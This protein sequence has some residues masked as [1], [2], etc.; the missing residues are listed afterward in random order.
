MPRLLRYLAG[1][2]AAAVV[3]CLGALVVLVVGTT[4]VENAGGLAREAQGRALALQLIGW[5]AVEYAYLYWPV[6]ALLGLLATGAQL[7]GQ[8]ELLAVQAGGT[9]PLTLARPFLGVALVGAALCAL[10]GEF[11]LPTTVQAKAHALEHFRARDA[12]TLF[13]AQRTQW[14][15]DDS[16]LLYLPEVDRSTATFC[17]PSV[18]QLQAGRI[19]SVTS[20]QTLRYHRAEASPQASLPPTKASAPP[21]KA[22]LPLTKA[23]APPTRADLPLTKASAPPAQ[24]GWWLH[25]AERHWV[26]RPQIEKFEDLAVPLRVSPRDLIDVT[27]N[28]RLLRFNDL[29]ALIDR[30]ERAGFATTAHR[31]ELHSRSAQP[32]SAVVLVLLALPWATRPDRRRTLAGTLGYGVVAVGLY[33]SVSQI[34]R[35]LAAG[36]DIAPIWGAWGAPALSCVLYLLWRWGRRLAQQ[37]FGAE[38]TRVS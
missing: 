37:K 5:S 6:A 35:V 19:I 30:R 10:C 2:Y 13:Y 4:L 38:Q 23:S 9:G 24:A 3:L 8:G 25:Q 26:H 22:D 17:R 34:F 27:G 21:T 36:H 12:A 7:A 14:F 33:L 11:C 29:R 31:L 28:P 32:L 20:A 15:L 1:R 16:L 18:Y